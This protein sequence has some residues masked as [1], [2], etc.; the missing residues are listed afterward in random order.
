[1]T[2]DVTRRQAAVFVD[3]LEAM[4]VQLIQQIEALEGAAAMP[5]PRRRQRLVDDARSRRV[6]LY[7]IRAHI[8]AL[9]KRYHLRTC[10]D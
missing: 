4:A 3:H 8:E 10:V 7:E 1:M 5:R 6:E 9:Q 2:D